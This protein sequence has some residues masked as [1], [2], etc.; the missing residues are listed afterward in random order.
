[1]IWQNFWD[2]RFASAL[3]LGGMDSLEEEQ[4]NESRLLS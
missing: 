1:M 2:F 3:R 4:G